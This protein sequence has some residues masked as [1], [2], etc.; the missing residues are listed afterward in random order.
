M[1]VDTLKEFSAALKDLSAFSTYICFFLSRS[2]ITEF[3]IKITSTERKIKHLRG[4]ANAL[5]KE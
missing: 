4:C 1:A 3:H 5:W 2:C